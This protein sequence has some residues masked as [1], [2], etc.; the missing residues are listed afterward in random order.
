MGIGALDADDIDDDTAD[1]SED[2]VS[3]L[4]YGP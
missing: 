4:E 2:S 1:D 3:D